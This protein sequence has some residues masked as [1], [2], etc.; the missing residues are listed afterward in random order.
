MRCKCG[1]E[2]KNWNQKYED[3][4]RECNVSIK[5]CLEEFIIHDYNDSK[6]DQ[7]GGL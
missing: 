1:N 2:I 4:C 3:Y 6:D 5:E 7:K